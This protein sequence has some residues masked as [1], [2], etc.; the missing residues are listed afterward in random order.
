MNTQEK[1]LEGIVRAQIATLGRVVPVSTAS[2]PSWRRSSTLTT[3]TKRP[4]TY[5]AIQAASW[6][7]TFIRT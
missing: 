7:M 2:P 4:D 1:W 5:H 6:M 3:S